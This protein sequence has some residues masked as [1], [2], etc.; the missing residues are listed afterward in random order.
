[1]KLVHLSLFELIS[2]PNHVTHFADFSGLCNNAKAD[3]SSSFMLWS[4]GLDGNIVTKKICAFK[5]VYQIIVTNTV[6][7]WYEV[8]ALLLTYSLAKSLVQIALALLSFPIFNQYD[9]GDCSSVLSS[10]SASRW[11][12][13][14][15]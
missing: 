6:A 5:H 4:A 11:D 3:D 13:V 12:H 2:S 15:T 10:K 8:R 14:W 9:T 1:M 7:S